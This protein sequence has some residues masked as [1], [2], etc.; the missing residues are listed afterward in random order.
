MCDFFM[1]YFRV[2]VVFFVFFGFDILNLF[3]LV[4]KSKKDII[5]WF[6]FN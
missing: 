3:Y 1:F 6:Y 2:I 5:E 4:E